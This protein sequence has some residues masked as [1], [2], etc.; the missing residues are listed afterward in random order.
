MQIHEITRRNINEA[1]FAA[2]LATGLDS[3]LSKVGVSG[4]AMTQGDGNGPGMDR[5]AALKMG[6]RLTQTLMPVMMKNW[7]ETV[8]RVVRQSTD[9]ATGQPATSPAALTPAS[10]NTLKMELNNIIGQA[11]E[12]RSRFD[13]TKLDQ[14][15]GDDQTTKSQAQVI[16]QAIVT[17]ADQ[18][19]KATLDPKAGVD[20]GRAWQSLMTDGIAP[21]QSV[22]AF[23]ASTG[24]V[25]TMSQVAKKLA[26]SLRLDD[27][28]IVKIRQVIKNPG[29]DQYAT[30]ILDKKTPATANSPLIK[31]FGQQAKLTDTELA[32]LIAYA[33]DAANDVAFKEIF[34]L[35]A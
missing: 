35:K 10:Q 24:S 16:T 20:V 27:G 15:V 2:G 26:D 33:Q 5:A 14:M 31:Q 3:A 32:S 29:G 11:I 8:S 23:D 17:A 25:I 28:D 13:Y 9:P 6:Q 19:Y 12:P 22:L 7:S 30:A 1:G 34:G 4:L 18:I 21:A